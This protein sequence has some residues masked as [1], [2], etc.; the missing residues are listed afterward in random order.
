MALQG[1]PI[2]TFINQVQL[3]VSGA[4]VSCTALS[5][6]LRGFDSAVTVRDVVAS[7]TYANTLV[8]LSVTGRTLRQALEQCATYFAVL[9]DGSVTVSDAFLRP[10]A[11]HY[12]YDYFWGVTYAFDLRKPIGNRVTRLRRLGEPVT[13]DARFSLVMNSYRA[14][15]A[16][17]FDGYQRCERI[18]EMQTDVSELLL[19]YLREHSP[20]TVDD[21]SAYEVILP[22]GRRA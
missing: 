11:A 16:G 1:S 21:A 8:V 12:N 13:D 22:D 3:A 18:R 14:T 2:A 17:D 4:E 9:A 6:D 5:N 15:G 10:K 20:I 7:Y 19:D